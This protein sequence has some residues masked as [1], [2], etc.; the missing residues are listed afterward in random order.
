MGIEF[1]SWISDQ[2][3]PNE[4]R[5]LKRVGGM[6]AKSTKFQSME[7]ANTAAYGN[8][9]LLDSTIQSAQADEYLYH[10]ALVHPA[11]I[12][13]PH[14]QRVLLIGGGEGA[15]LREVLKYQSVETVV[16]VDLDHELV[17]FCQ[18][19]LTSW[20]QGTFDDPRLTL[21][22]TDGRA[23]L[24]QNTTKF[25][26][27]ILDITDALVDGPAI[28]LYTKE[29]YALCQQR[30]HDNG[31]LVVQGFALSPMTWTEHATIRRTVGSLFAVVRSY[32]IFVPS[33]ACTWGF[34]I[35]TN[36]IDPATLSPDKISQCLKD[37]NL[38]DRI[39]GYDEVAHLGMFGLPKDLRL[40]LLQPGNILEDS[41]PLVFE[42]E[43]S[44]NMS[45]L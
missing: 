34:I 37:R 26:V 22:H 28:A 3:S 29:F 44:S 21:L 12:T 2:I 36:G 41:K 16:M 13:H 5:L 40:K 35:A 18:Q 6:E 27:I 24:E 31:V 23:Y 10:E 7:F 25:D 17:E 4:I 42:P 8:I 30:L 14:P 32:T 19:K 15:T 45:N 20:H 43:S 33:F 39:K 11:M 9:L 38:V 1:H